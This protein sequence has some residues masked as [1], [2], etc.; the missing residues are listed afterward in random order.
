LQIQQTEQQQKQFDEELQLQK[1]KLAAD[2]T[3]QN[4]AFQMKDAMLQ[5][6]SEQTDFLNQLKEEAAQR[7]ET[8]LL[9]DLEMNKARKSQIEQKLL[10]GQTEDMTQEESLSG[11]QSLY[12]NGQL[13]DREYFAAKTAIEQG[14]SI[15]GLLKEPTPSRT[16]ELT[17]YQQF[18]IAQQMNKD[19]PSTDVERIQTQISDSMDAIVKGV[20]ALANGYATMTDKQRD[21]YLNAFM[22]TYMNKAVKTGDIAPWKE[23]ESDILKLKSS[24]DKEYPVLT[25]DIFGKSDNTILTQAPSVQD[26]SSALRKVFAERK[27][28]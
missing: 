26:L 16:P 2:V 8:K 20:N 11:L 18:Q 14:K 12:Q 15:T 25:P 17:P 9:S 10:A 23:V 3:Q 24:L 6:R 28:K 21:Q 27:T 22:Q 13:T 19:I 4:L 5:Q 7:Q 1:E